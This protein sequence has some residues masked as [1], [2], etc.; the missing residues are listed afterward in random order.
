[1]NL[2]QNQKKHLRGLAHALHPVVMVGQH[3][4]SPAVAK[5]LDI[6]L[7]AHELVKVSVRVGERDARELVFT[8]LAQ[9]TSSTVIQRIGNIGVYYRPRKDQPRIVLPDAASA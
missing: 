7:A 8:E 2:T 4:F 1:M 9:H 3:G 5:E 6:A